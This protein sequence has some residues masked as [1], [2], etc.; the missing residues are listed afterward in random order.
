MSVKRLRLP[1]SVAYPIRIVA[2]HVSAGQRV[3]EGDPVYSLITGSGARG[4]MRAPVSGQIVEGPLS[5]NTTFEA[6]AS[7]LAIE[8]DTPAPA[9]SEPPKVQESKPQEVAAPQEPEPAAQ[10][11]DEDAAPSP[12]FVGSASGSEAQPEPPADPQPAAPEAQ[13]P[14]VLDTTTPSPPSVTPRRVNPDA[15]LRSVIPDDPPSHR[16]RG[17]AIGAV[18]L[19]LIAAAIW[20]WPQLF[21]YWASPTDPA[22]PAP[23][24]MSD[25]PIGLPAPLSAGTGTANA[26]AP[27]AQNDTALRN[28]PAPVAAPGTESAPEE[29]STPATPSQADAA[30]EPASSGFEIQQGYILRNGAP[31]HGP[32]EAIMPLS[33]ELVITG[34]CTLRRL[35]N[36]IREVATGTIVTSITGACASPVTGA[37]G[38]RDGSYVITTPREHYEIKCRA[39]LSLTPCGQDAGLIYDRRFMN[40]QGEVT[41]RCVGRDYSVFF[42]DFIGAEC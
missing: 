28:D 30:R 20:M 21:T 32:Y 18:F 25:A 9:V 33:N 11:A 15:P 3:A 2:V 22:A 24:I 4:V 8:G 36:D 37:D 31:L 40:A 17:I 7:V 6:P 26:P 27:S 14:L 29:S 13:E 42:P 1:Q 38:L 19:L 12:A 39:E 5:V 23:E 35:G 41:R 34:R 10:V 16:G